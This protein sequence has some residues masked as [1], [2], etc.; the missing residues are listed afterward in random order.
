MEGSRGSSGDEG[1]TAESWSY[2]HNRGRSRPAGGTAHGAE[3]NKPGARTNIKKLVLGSCSVTPEFSQH[4]S[5]ALPGTCP[6]AQEVPA[7]P[8]SSRASPQW[9]TLAAPST[10]YPR[11]PLLT[12]PQYCWAV[13]H[14]LKKM[15]DVCGWPAV[16]LP[17][18]FRIL[19]PPHPPCPG[20]NT[21]DSP[22]AL[23]VPSNWP[24]APEPNFRSA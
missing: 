4:P 6:V 7:G 24:R 11:S 22:S 21:K 16:R 12:A 20:P 3:R 14:P 1:R 8:A 10:S 15:Q 9:P 18:Q 23:A 17:L 2:L 13:R 5:W 19:G